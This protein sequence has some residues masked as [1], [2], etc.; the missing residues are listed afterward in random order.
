MLF[1]YTGTKFASGS[2]PTT[3][4]PDILGKNPKD[5]EILSIPKTSKRACQKPNK[6]FKNNY[7]DPQKI[8][9]AKAVISFTQPDIIEVEKKYPRNITIGPPTSRAYLI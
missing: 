6:P 8:N 5:S 1:L 9:S 3:T 4:D 2:K 7:L